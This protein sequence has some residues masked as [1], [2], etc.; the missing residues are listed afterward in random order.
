MSTPWAGL[1]VL[2]LRHSSQVQI[3]SLPAL[4]DRCPTI[5]LALRRRSWRGW[6]EAPVRWRLTLPG[7]S[8]AFIAP[9]LCVTGA[10]AQTSALAPKSRPFYWSF[11]LSP[12]P[13]FLLG[14]LGGRLRSPLAQIKCLWLISWG[15]YYQQRW[16]PLVQPS[17]G[18]TGSFVASPLKQDKICSFLVRPQTFNS[19]HTHKHTHSCMQPLPESN[20]S[21]SLHKKTHTSPLVAAAVHASLPYDCACF[22]TDYINLHFL[23]LSRELNL[24]SIFVQ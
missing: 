24:F 4:I 10:Q 17:P 14:H 6:V 8:I 16:K 5:P 1:T 3:V 7:S 18:N 19:T 12:H 13:R 9:R 2:Q 15:C 22:S 20:G 21:G 11:C 23:I